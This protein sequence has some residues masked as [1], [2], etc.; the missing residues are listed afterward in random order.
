MN[1]TTTFH[2][3]RPAR[4]RLAPLLLPAGFFLS[5]GFVAARSAAQQSDPGGSGASFGISDISASFS[6][7]PESDIERDG[8]IGSVELSHYEFDA[9]ISL[10]APETW[11]FSTGFSWSR[12]ELE[13]TGAVPL[14]E[15][16]ESFGLNFTVMKDLGEEIG[17]GWSA[18]AILNPSFASDSGDFSGDSFSF[19]GIVAISKEMGPDLSWN[20]GVV[21]M[22]RGE[23]KVLPMVG[24]HWSFAPDWSLDLGFPRTGITY[25][26]T[27]ALRVTTGATF[28]GGTYYI[29]DTPLSEPRE[30]YMEYQEIRFGLGAEYRFS[31]NLSIGIEGGAVLERKFDFYDENFELDGK[32]AGYGRISLSY[33]F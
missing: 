24:L 29:E 5:F 4:P 19:L 28:H 7:S 33:H 22:T 12:D 31:Q 9:T 8:V 11:N 26:V 6:F 25:Q 18:M 2:F 3:V 32:S 15:K 13:F 14:P 10:P 23:N 21:T 27:E 20:L 1:H 30:T 17:P 16:L